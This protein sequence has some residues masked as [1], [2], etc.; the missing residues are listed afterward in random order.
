MLWPIIGP[1]LASSGHRAGQGDQ[2]LSPLG[3]P[4]LEEQSLVPQVRAVLSSSPVADT[5]EETSSL[6]G[7][8]IDLASPMGVVELSC[9]KP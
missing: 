7:E 8:W 1:V 2:M 5:T 3:G 9:L 4:T 6:A